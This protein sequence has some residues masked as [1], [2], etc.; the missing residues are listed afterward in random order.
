MQDLN[1]KLCQVLR[2]A[3]NSERAVVWTRLGEKALKHGNLDTGCVVYPRGTV[4]AVCALLALAFFVLID[5]CQ[6]H[7]RN[8]LS[9]AAIPAIGSILLGGTLGLCISIWWSCRPQ[10]VWF[11]SVSDL[12]RHAPLSNAYRI[13]FIAFA[14]FLF[15]TIALY[16][17]LLL[18][19]IEIPSIESYETNASVPLAV[20]VPG[21]SP[22]IEADTPSSVNGVDNETMNSTENASMNATR[23][24]ARHM[25]SLGPS[26]SV[27]W[28]YA[29]A[30]GLA[31][32]GTV[33]FDGK[34]SIRST[35]HV[36]G[37]FIFAFGV[38]KHS[39]QSNFWLGLPR[40]N[41]QMELPA[42]LAASLKFRCNLAD[43]GPLVLMLGPLSSQ[44][45]ATHQASSSARST[46]ALTMKTFLRDSGM[47][48]AWALMQW[49]LVV[50]VW[51]FYGS[52]AVDFWYAGQ[53]F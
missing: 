32:Q 39:A 5:V 1:G 35:V 40:V 42:A 22:G 29:A 46:Q 8:A 53:F 7:G 43:Y 45:M 6:A 47:D 48:K 23:N 33:T 17:E 11:P 52:F 16:Q 24:N 34:L 9:A 51:M 20:P 14:F 49:V 12:S 50:L 2:P 30:A 10:G 36:V 4:K 3:D 19:Q 41:A 18:P 28:G 31:M 38:M 25:L 37:M 27:Y 21:P 26:R 13:G 15:A 44:A